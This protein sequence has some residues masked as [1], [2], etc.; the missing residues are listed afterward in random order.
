VT[1]HLYRLEFGLAGLKIRSPSGVLS[2]MSTTTVFGSPMDITLQELALE[3]LFPSDGF[4]M[5]V[6]Q[7]LLPAP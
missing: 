4:T 5:Q 1:Q 6:L 3:T 2:F 7:A